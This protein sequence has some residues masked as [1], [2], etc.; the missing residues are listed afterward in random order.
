MAFTNHDT[1]EINC[2]ILYLG[3]EGSGKTEN[4]RSILR[5]TLPDIKNGM[6]ELTSQGGKTSYF[7]FLPVSLGHVKDYH[8]K[9][10]LFALPL[11]S[12]Y[13]TTTKVLMRGLDGFVFVA[14]SRVDYLA[15]N[16]EAM[17]Q[18]EQLLREQGYNML[19]L[20][21]VIQYNKRDLEPRVPL[22]I[23]SRELNPNEAADCE[24]IATQSVGSVET[25]QSVAK[26]V[27]RKLAPTPA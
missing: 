8:I 19:D 16:V 13:E 12:P 11:N 25:L 3:P 20:A 4:L 17:A 14:D 9:L 7:D 18:T 26:Q 15:E 27:L 2:K 1:K 23:L 6:F 10:H 5:L 24:A 22:D 21:R